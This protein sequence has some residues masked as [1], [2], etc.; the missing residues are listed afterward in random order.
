MFVNKDVLLNTVNSS[1]E[2]RL[3][4]INS[5]EDELVTRVNLWMGD[6]LR[7]VGGEPH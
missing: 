1:H 2:K 6:L 4:H 7:R 5:R 3:L